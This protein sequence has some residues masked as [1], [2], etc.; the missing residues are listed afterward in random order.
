MQVYIAARH[1]TARHGTARHGTARHG[2]ARH[3]TARHVLLQLCN[4][5]GVCSGL[6]TLILWW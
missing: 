5:I 4:T 6:A 1:V 3:G 2:T